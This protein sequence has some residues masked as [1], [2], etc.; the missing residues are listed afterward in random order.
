MYDRRENRKKP[1]KV[2][3][4]NG[5]P[6]REGNTAA[7]LAEME[8]IFRKNGIETVTMQIGGEMIRG[9]IAAAAV[10]RPENAFLTTR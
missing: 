6:R 9:C 1:L 7:A 3:M 5:S 8:R 2:L 4:I 10:Q